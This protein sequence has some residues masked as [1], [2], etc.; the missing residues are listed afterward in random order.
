MTGTIRAVFDSI[1]ELIAGLSELVQGSKEIT[2]AISI[3]NETTE[4]LRNAVHTIGGSS[5]TIDTAIENVADLSLQN[6][7]AFG[8]IVSGIQAVSISGTDLTKISLENNRI[9]EL[10]EQDIRRFKTRENGEKEEAEEVD[11]VQE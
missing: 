2:D 8:E 10:I 1:N 9:S 11:P 7:A 5:R 4:A 3:L 6:N